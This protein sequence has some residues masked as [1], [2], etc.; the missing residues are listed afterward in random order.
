MKW[1]VLLLL[2]FQVFTQD[3][4]YNNC[5][6]LVKTYYV[7]YTPE[8]HYYWNVIGGTVVSQNANIITVQ[9]PSTVGQ[10]SILASCAVN[11]ECFGE[12]SEYTISIVECPTMYFPTAF[13]PNGDGY[14]EIYEIKGAL[15][16][17]IKYM[18][19][20]NRWGEKIIEANNNI[21]WDG[22][23]Y[24]VGVYSLIILVEN[25]KYIKNITLIR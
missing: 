10:Y 5:E 8:K 3:T 20:Y 13:T 15:S 7:E 22:G 11:G 17:D 23:D 4:T 1:W 6:D 14:N 12:I 9:W 24:P 18:A 21:L 25:E 2:P 19:I 16:N